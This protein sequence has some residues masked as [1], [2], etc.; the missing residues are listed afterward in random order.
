MAEVT[1]STRL[2]LIQESSEAVPVFPSSGADYLELQEGFE[3]SPEFAELETNILS[4]SIGQSK[5]ILGLEE[6]SLSLS[7]FLKHSGVEGQAPSMGILLESALGQED[8]RATER[9]TVAGSTAGDATNPPVLNVDAGEGVEFSRG[10]AILLKRSPYEIRNVKSVSGD[11]LTLNFNLENAAPASGVN[12]GKN[13]RYSPLDSGHPTL[14][15]HIYSGN[16]GARQLM[17]GGRVT[18]ATVN[19]PASELINMDATID[20]VEYY[21]DPIQIVLGASDAIDFNDGAPQSAV[22]TAGTYKDPHDA[23][24]AL[25]TAMDA[26]STDNITVSYSDSTGKFTVASDGITFAVDWATTVNTLGAKFGFTADDTGAT[27]YESD[28]A[29]DFS[30]EFTPTYDDSDPLVAKDNYIVLGDH[31]DNAC[32]SAANVTFTVANEKTDILSVCASSGKEGSVFSGREVTVEIDALLERYDADKFK[33]FRRGE[34]TEFMYVGGTKSGGD[35]EAGKCFNLY[36]PSATISSFQVADR[37]GLVS[38]N[39]TLTSFVDDGLGEVYV[40]F[41]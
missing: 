4:G 39:L 27:S 40:N 19:I 18:E 3:I 33:R 32:I 13:V 38:L 28:S 34:T 16:G 12:L 26:Q 8:V 5:T 37:D 17:S 36:M 14:S 22:V 10:D 30:S 11:A 41:L 9:D 15:A 2:A 24:A 29:L 6:P 35:W 25:Q 23:A 1:R 21:Y 20:G 31:A 7:H